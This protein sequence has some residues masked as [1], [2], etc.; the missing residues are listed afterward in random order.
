TV[1]ARRFRVPTPLP[2]DPYV[3]VRHAHLVD[4]DTE[5]GPV[6]D[7]RETE[8]HTPAIVDT[9]SELEE[10]PSE[11]EEFEASEPSDTRITSPHSSASSD[12]TATL[13]PDHPLTQTL[14][15]PTPTRVLFHR[16]TARMAVRT[17]STLS[18]GMSARIAEAAA[19]SSSLLYE[20]SDS[21]TERE[22]SKEEGPVSEDEGP[23]SEEEEE[24]AAPEG[25]Q[26]AGEMPSTFEVGQSS[27]SL[28]EHEGAERTLSSPEWSSSSLPVSSSSP[29]VPTPVASPVT[30]P[31]ATIAVDE[32]EFLE[33]FRARAREGY[34]D[35]QCYM[36]RQTDAQRAALWHA[37]YDT[38]RENHDLRMQIA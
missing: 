31:A 37:I 2:D 4:T 32:D 5:F 14:P 18:L 16:R 22:G 30:T 24:E 8:A 10:A 21:G 29:T 20:S 27:R 7:L 28:P 33:E 23:G 11:I 19:L 9:E 35:I 34:G 25:Q 3:A 13:S 17:Q 15:T 6:E 26:Q 12:S 1:R 36:E 38:Q